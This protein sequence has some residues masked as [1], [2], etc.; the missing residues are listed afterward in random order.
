MT[1]VHFTDAAELDLEE[2]GDHIAIESPPSAQKLVRRLREACAKLSYSPARNSRVPRFEH[3]ALRRTV[4]GQYLIF[5]R[6]EADRITILRILHG[7]RDY[8]AILFP[9]DS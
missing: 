3:R 6:I 7:A 9:D 1:E 8:Q 5:F 4:V 2:I